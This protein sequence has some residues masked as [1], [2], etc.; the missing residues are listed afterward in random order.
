MKLYIE[1]IF[2]TILFSQCYVFV[3]IFFIY[4]N[5]CCVWYVMLYCMSYSYVILLCCSS[6][7]IYVQ[8]LFGWYRL[9]C[10]CMLGLS[11]LKLR[12]LL[13]IWQP[14]HQTLWIKKGGGGK[15]L[16]FN[17]YPAEL[18]D[19]NFQPLEIV[20]RYRDP[21]PQVVE[22]YSFLFNLRPNIDKSW[23]F[24]HTFNSQYRWSD[25]LIKQVKNDSSRD[26]QDKGLVCSE[27]KKKQFPLCRLQ[28]ISSLVLYFLHVLSM[29][30]VCIIVMLIA[31]RLSLLN[32]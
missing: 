11:R 2:K 23:M 9:K 22:N 15:Q 10:C 3:E 18:F 32:C 24:K 6:I 5:W 12:N 13:L 21:Q 29:M 17:H 30:Q 31:A 26:Q 28:H 16:V 25:W 7:C 8:F 20:S 19:F 14:K 4:Y 1:E 27:W